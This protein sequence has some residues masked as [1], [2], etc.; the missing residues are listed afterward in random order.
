MELDDLNEPLSLPGAGMS[1]SRMSISPAELAK[2]SASMETLLANGVSDET[3]T[4]AMN[5]EY[6]MTEME[7]DQLKESVANRMLAESTAR[8]PYKKVFAEKRLHG[9]IR[10]SAKRNA[11]GAVANLEGQLA[12][13]QGTEEPT[14]SRV[15]IDARLQTAT[16][17]VLAGMPQEQVDELIAEE[18]ALL[19]AGTK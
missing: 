5:S 4:R 3:I 19:A 14:E 2:R 11:W 6:S 7:S 10:A 12:R 16:L 8:G 17:H 15:T 1:G 13:I 18:L 9:H